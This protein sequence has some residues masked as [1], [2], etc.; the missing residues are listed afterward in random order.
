MSKFTFMVYP[1]LGEGEIHTKELTSKEALDSFYKVGKEL[2]QRELEGED[3]FTLFNEGLSQKNLY[4]GKGVV[5]YF[6]SSPLKTLEGEALPLTEARDYFF[7]LSSKKRGEWITQES[8]ALE[9]L[10]FGT[11]MTLLQL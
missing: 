6:I 8:E 11:V 1:P 10:S 2:F 3:L 9:E 7:S 5:R 4:G